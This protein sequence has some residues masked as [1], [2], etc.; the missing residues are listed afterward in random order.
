MVSAKK[1]IRVALAEVGY[2]EKRTPEHLDDKLLNAGY[3]NYTKYARD[4]AEIPG[5]YNGN[6]NGYAWC[7][8]FV[9]WCFVRA[10]GEKLARR[11]L[12]HGPYGAGCT[13]SAWYYRKNGRFFSDPRAGDQIFFGSGVDDCWHTGLVCEVKD[14]RV[15]TVEGNTSAAAEVEPNGGGVYKKSYSLHDGAIVGYGRPNYENEEEP[16]TGKEI[17]DALT[18]YLSHRDFPEGMKKELEQAESMGITDGSRPMM[19]ASRG[20]AAIMVKRAAEKYGAYLNEK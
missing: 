11:L 7:D 16:M 6:K 10:Y 12:F 18:E 8:V 2:L 20:E 19:F 3:N 13:E 5:F 14:G 15:H 17:Y 4:L 9:D 1:V